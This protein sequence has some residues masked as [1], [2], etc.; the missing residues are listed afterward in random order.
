MMP[1]KTSRSGV[2]VD[3]RNLLQEATPLPSEVQAIDEL[4]LAIPRTSPLTMD[5]DL[6]WHFYGADLAIQARQ[7]GLQALVIEAPCF[8]N[9]L[10]DY[11]LPRTFHRAAGRFKR[12][13]ASELPISTPCI[14]LK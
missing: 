11:H 4:L 14:V 7:A 6:G 1:G 3:R 12:K 9:S 13:W 2:V 10:N 5:P 8:H